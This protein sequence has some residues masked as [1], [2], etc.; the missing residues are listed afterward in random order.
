MT[1]Y[2]MSIYES[3]G[4]LLNVLQN[5]QTLSGGVLGVAFVLVPFIVILGTVIPR[6]GLITGLSISCM[7]SFVLSLLLLTIGLTTQAVVFGLFVFTILT[8]LWSYWDTGN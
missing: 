6:Y 8:G 2:N 5:S 3:G 1:Y 7:I 4:N